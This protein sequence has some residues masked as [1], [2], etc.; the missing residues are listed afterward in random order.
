MTRYDCADGNALVADM[1]ALYG[2]TDPGIRYG[3][4]KHL[5]G[6]DPWRNFDPGFFP[7]PRVECLPEKPKSW[8]MPEQE[9]LL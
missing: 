2:P 7:Y 3:D 1:E 4:Y 9:R 6:P 8:P 5:A